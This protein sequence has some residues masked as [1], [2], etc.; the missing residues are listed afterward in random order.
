M[1]IGSVEEAPAEGVAI[2]TLEAGT[3]LSLRTRNSAYR[4]TVVDGARGKVLV[5]GG[6]RFPENTQACFLGSDAP[7]ALKINWLGV[8]QRMRILTG[9]RR[10]STSAVQSIT[11][12][13]AHVSVGNSHSRV[14]PTEGIIHSH[15]H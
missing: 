6:L 11:I 3:S 12:E 8:G 1:S 15:A 14:I 9:D 2:D 10:V 4:L 5:Q 7:G 13:H